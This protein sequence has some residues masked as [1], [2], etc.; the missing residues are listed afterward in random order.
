MFIGSL[1][2]CTIYTG[3]GKPVAFSFNFQDAPI[4]YIFVHQIYGETSI[5]SPPT[6]TPH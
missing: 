3:V 4:N 6:K 1:A 5:L 2:L